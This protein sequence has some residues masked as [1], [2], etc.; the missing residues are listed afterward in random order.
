MWLRGRIFMCRSC[1]LRRGR[2]LRRRFGRSI[3]K[4]TKSRNWTSFTLKITLKRVFFIWWGN[5]VRLR[6]DQH[7]ISRNPTNNGVG[8]LC[9]IRLL[10]RL[11]QSSL[12]KWNHYPNY[13]GKT[14][15]IILRWMILSTN[16]EESKT[17]QKLGIS[18]LI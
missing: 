5:R 8:K 16:S 10:R 17:S 7:R 1:C 6:R 4:T 2:Y 15:E 13:N 9:Q 3:K 14:T 12:L 11:I 18:N